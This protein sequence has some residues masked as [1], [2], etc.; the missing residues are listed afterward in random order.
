MPVIARTRNGEIP[1]SIYF[2]Y[3]ENFMILKRMI[4]FHEYYLLVEKRMIYQ[5]GNIDELIC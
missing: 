2:S 4:C 5:V 3:D 1:N